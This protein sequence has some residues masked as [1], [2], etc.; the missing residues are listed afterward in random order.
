MKPHRLQVATAPN[1][2]FSVRRDHLPNINSRW[3]C[4][5]Q[6]ELIHFHRGSG[7]QF[8]GDNIRRFHPGDVV[9]VGA[10][11]PHYWH[12]DRDDAAEASQQP[13]STVIHF[14]ENFWGDRFL[15]LPENAVLKA[16]LDRARRGIRLTGETAQ[17]VAG[18]METLYKAEGTYQLIALMECL[19]SASQADESCLLTSMGFQH[20]ASE[21]EH[22]RINTIYAYTLNHFQEKI[23]LDDVASLAGLVPNSFCRY[24]RSRTGKQYTQFL[25][26]IRIGNACKLLI[27]TNMSIKQICYESGF[28]NFTCFYKKFKRITGK[29]PLQ[30]QRSFATSPL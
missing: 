14:T 10:N 1:R 17:R 29:S 21:V 13:Y 18:L 28:N 24:F 7:T 2:S 3:H 25:L 16:V 30:Y 6:V 5:T 27:N 15:N 8:V 12:Y 9:L 26:E 23:R 20:E 4:H 22:E 11:L 19:L